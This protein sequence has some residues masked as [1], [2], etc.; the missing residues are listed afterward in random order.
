M[1]VDYA[2]YPT[3]LNNFYW[4]KVDPFGKWQELIDKCNRVKTELAPEQLKGVNF[5]D[6]INRTLDG[7]IVE[8]EYGDIVEKVATKLINHHKQQDYISAVVKTNH[9]KVMLYG[10]VDYSYPFKYIDLKTTEKYR[11]GKYEKSNQHGGYMLI[12]YLN[13]GQIKDFH[14]LVTDF[15]DMYI[16]SY[17]PTMEIFDKFIFNLLEFIDWLEVNKKH[18]TDDKI[19]G[20]IK[21]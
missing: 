17:Q 20:N 21:S 16:E 11:F 13:G 19:F 3:L 9:G 4:Y 6:I 10:F 2:I 1:K 5:E 8:H 7:E 15:K 14:Y 18:I 12:N